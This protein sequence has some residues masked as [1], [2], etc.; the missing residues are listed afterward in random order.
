M[1]RLIQEGQKLKRNSRKVWKEKFG[2]K[3]SREFQL[4]IL[5]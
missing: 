2:G 1:E 5:L 4:K 3:V